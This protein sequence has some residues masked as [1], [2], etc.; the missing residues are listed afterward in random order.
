MRAARITQYGPPGVIEIAEMMRPIPGD[1]QLL[2]RVEAAGVEPWDALIR[3]GKSGV[4]QSL[5]LILGSDLAGVVE[6]VGPEVLD[7]KAGDEV[8]GATNE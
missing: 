3:E 4:S 2:V 1:G 6:M 5:P 7:F 8:Y